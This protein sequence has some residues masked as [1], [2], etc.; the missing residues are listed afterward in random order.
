MI[1][2]IFVAE[3]STMQAIST[4]KNVWRATRYL[5]GNSADTKVSLSYLER[6]HCG[7]ESVS[8]GMRSFF[9]CFV[10]VAQYSRDEVLGWVPPQP[11]KNSINTGTRTCGETWCV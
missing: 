8:T 3:V 11:L 2:E 4:T 1:G 5:V 10:H 7:I 9:L 6:L